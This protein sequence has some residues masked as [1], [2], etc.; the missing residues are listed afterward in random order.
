MKPEILM[1]APM[2][3]SCMDALDA[4]FTVHKTFEAADPDA[5]V[6]AVASRV[7]GMAVSR[8]C[9]AAMMARLPALEI[10]SSFGVGYDSIDV[11]AARAR[12]VR[13]TN[14]PDVLNDAVAE[15]TVGMMVALAR[16]LPEGD[17]YVRSGRWAAEGAMPLTRQ[18]TGATAGILGLG[19]IGK[20]IA[21][22]LT[23]MR[24]E[25]AYHGRRAQPDQ[26]YR[27]H[28]SL[29]DMARA[30]DWL[31]VI[32]PASPETIGIID[33]GVLDA[34]GPDGCL[35]NVARGSLVDEPAL[36]AALAEGR[37]AGA[38]LDVF[39]DEPQVPQALRDAPNT[40]LAPHVGSATHHTRW[41]MGDMVVRNLRAHFEGR[42]L[43]SP[44]V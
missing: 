34:L 40:V 32:A 35:V 37:I 25:V 41:A 19:R 26:P 39:A 15:L 20:E 1:P 14:T 27:F 24:M 18:L 2:L 29:H 3:Q 9:A 23:A 22:R 13:V 6:A 4:A 44:V 12:G 28:D 42:P 21:R 30:V 36:I 10:I 5:A 8:G 43:L 16:R 11:E 33:A 38:A 7:R 31:V 17:A